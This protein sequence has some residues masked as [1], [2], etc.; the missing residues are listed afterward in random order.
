MSILTADEVARINAKIEKF[1]EGKKLERDPRVDPNEPIHAASSFV[2]M[3]SLC[4]RIAQSKGFWT[5]W[6]EKVEKSLRERYGEGSSFALAMSV[7]EF[8]DH[9]RMIKESSRE[10]YLFLM[11]EEIIEALDALRT[12]KGDDAL[13]EELADVVIRIMDFCSKYFENGPRDLYESITA[14]MAVNAARPKLHGKAY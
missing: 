5:G 10:L 7:V 12:G 14:K 4:G 11:V 9:T 6:K 13:M 1:S 3:T 8:L 2:E